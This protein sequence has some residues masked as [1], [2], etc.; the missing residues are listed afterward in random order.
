MIC[1]IS[2]MAQL[3]REKT[4]ASAGIDEVSSGQWSSDSYD[5]FQGIYPSLFYHFF[6]YIL[7]DT[8]A[9]CL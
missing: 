5:S 2:Q 7:K 6:N 4:E 3:E 9:S 1:M 8:E